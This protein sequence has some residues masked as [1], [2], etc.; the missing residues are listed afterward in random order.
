MNLNE[1]ILI[2]NLLGILVWYIIFYLILWI[3]NRAKYTKYGWYVPLIMLI[4]ILFLNNIHLGGGYLSEYFM[5]PLIYLIIIITLPQDTEKWFL[6]F[7]ALWS[8]LLLDI[9]EYNPGVNSSSLVL[10]AFLKPYLEKVFIPKNSIDEKDKLNLQIL[11]LRVF[12]SYSLSLI[13]IHNL[14]LFL[15]EYFS[16]SNIFYLIIKIILSSIITYIVIIIL[17]LFS[18]KRKE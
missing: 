6:I 14:F 1:K 5:P 11:G 13:F 8:S 9:F 16:F 10:I 18:Y 17:Q 12:S 4:Q 15:L 2:T 3:S 7:Y